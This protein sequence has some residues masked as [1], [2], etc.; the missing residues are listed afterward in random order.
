VI[1]GKGGP[2]TT[3]T[4]VPYLISKGVRGSITPF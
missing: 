1:Y 2:I 4:I 3:P